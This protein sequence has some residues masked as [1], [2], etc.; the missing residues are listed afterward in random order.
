[1]DI[2]N[3][4]IS[5]LGVVLQ[6]DGRAA[7]LTGESGLLGVL[8][9]FDSM[10]VIALLGALENHFEIAFQDDELSSSHF[11]TVA[12]LTD[13]VRKKLGHG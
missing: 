4:I 9:E 2:E 10:S 6:L 3:E 12:T 8:P 1:M 5:I 13:L 7:E 11:E